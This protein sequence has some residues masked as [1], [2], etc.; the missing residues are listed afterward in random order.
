MKLNTFRFHQQLDKRSIADPY[1]NTRSEMQQLRFSVRKGQTVAV[2]ASSR[3]ISNI[4]PIMCGVVDHFR[5]SGLEPFIVPA[6]GSHAGGT[7]ESQRQLLYD[8]GLTES[9]LGC[10][11]RS[12]METVVLGELRIAPNDTV[13]SDCIPVH[14]DR[15]TSEADHV[16][17][18]NRIK[19]HTRFSG[20]IESGLLKMLMIGLG[21][22]Q[23]ACVYHRAISN[24]RFSTVI[25]QAADFLM[26]KISL[27]GG[28]GIVENGEGQTALLK[29]LH[30]SDLLTGEEK[31]LFLAK[32][33]MPQLPFQEIDLLLIEQIGKN[34]SGTGFDSNIVGRKFDDH[35]AVRSE[36]PI[37][38]CIAVLGLT[39]ETAGN[40]NGIGMAEF[41]LSSVLREIDWQKTRLNAITANHVSAAMI[42]LDYQTEEEIINT[43]WKTLGQPKPENFRVVWIRDTLHLET[44]TASEALRTEVIKSGCKIIETESI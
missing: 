31:L 36:R 7:A 5:E 25:R 30:A 29:A 19:S 38:H 16:F 4:V 14:F 1:A 12:S 39:P 44:I 8:Y 11:I 20:T 9:V 15:I 6:M 13:S 28:L 41:C 24:D 27:L 17:L 18:V 34:I 40:A 2:T 33:L 42:P 35:K 26:Q 22:D 10:P 21:N 37:I 3:G 43:A 32:K 23:G